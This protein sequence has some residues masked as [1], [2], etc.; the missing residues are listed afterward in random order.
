MISRV[1]LRGISFQRVI[2]AIV[3]R[4]KRIPGTL[5]F[6]YSKQGR[7]NSNL[8]KKFHNKH[9]GETCVLLANGPSLKLTDLSKV[10][11]FKT[12]GLNRIYLFFEELG[13]QTDYLVCV[14]DLVLSQFQEEISNCKMPKFVHW[15]MRSL[16]NGSDNL[17]YVAK[18]LFG[19]SFSV[20]ASKSLDSGVTV[21]YAA[22]QLIYYMGFEKVLVVGMDHNFAFKGT[23]NQTQIRKEEKDLNHFHPNYFPKGVKWQTPDLDSSDYYYKIAKGVFEKNGR[24]IID[25]TING[26]CE[27]FEKGKLEDYVQS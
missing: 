22:L 3:R 4:V 6:M 1:Q 15:R 25:C 27:I 18:K 17:F 23:A 11:K 7:T 16:Y 12:F 19:S 24:V 20:D 2:N 13:F 8:I 26:K 21:T 9:L 10:K 14:N 5:S